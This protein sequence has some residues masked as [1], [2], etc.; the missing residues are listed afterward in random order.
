MS[1]LQQQN[2]EAFVQM[3]TAAQ[4]LDSQTVQQITDVLQPDQKTSNTLWI[5]LVGVLGG[6]LLLGIAGFIF[7]LGDGKDT[8]ALLTA[9]TAI[10]TGLLGLFT[11]SPVE[12]KEG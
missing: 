1:T 12:K 5:I 6:A 8:A 7:L 3:A 2:A 10:L 4:G 9:F 11:K